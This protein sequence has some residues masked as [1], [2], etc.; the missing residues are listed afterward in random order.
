MTLARKCDM[1]GKL[2]EPDA[3]G[4]LRIN[5]DRYTDAAGAGDWRTTWADLCASCLAD[6]VRWAAKML[7]EEQRYELVAKACRAAAKRGGSPHA[8]EPIPTPADWEE[9]ISGRKD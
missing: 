2:L 1:C 5:I 8:L 4:R 7:S 6:V 3:A 9:R